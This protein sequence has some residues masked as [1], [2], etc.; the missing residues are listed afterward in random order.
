MS[1]FSMDFGIYIAQGAFVD[2]DSLFLYHHLFWSPRHYVVGWSFFEGF[3]FLVG[4]WVFAHGH[5]LIPARQKERNA[6]RINKV[7]W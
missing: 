1:V 6:S 5:F 4:Q 3:T 7:S 2:L